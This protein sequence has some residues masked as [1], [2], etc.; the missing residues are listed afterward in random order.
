MAIK[1]TIILVITLY[2]AIT[3]FIAPHLSAIS[4]SDVRRTSFLLILM[5][6]GPVHQL[7]ITLVELQQRT[8]WANWPER[9][10]NSQLSW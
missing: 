10:E 2:F 7:F 9:L 1:Q 8:H 5:A 3:G 6:S 4:C